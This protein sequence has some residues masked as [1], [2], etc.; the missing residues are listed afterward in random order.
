ML[1]H[2][3]QALNAAFGD[4][5]GVQAGTVYGPVTVHARPKDRDT[6][7]V[8]TVTPEE[9][10]HVTHEFVHPRNFGLAARVLADNRVV[11]LC[12]RGAGRSFAAR[13]LLSDLAPKDVAELDPETPLRG[14][15]P[16]D[17]TPGH[18]YVWEAPELER[19]TLADR[20]FR[21]IHGVVRAA[22]CWLVI[23]LDQASRAPESA[24]TATVTLGP[25][26]ASQVALETI[27][28]R[29]GADGSVEGPTLVLKRCLTSWLAEDDPPD[30]AVRAADFAIR[31]D[32]GTCELADASA[33]L[34]D[35]LD[36]SVR[37]WFE[38]WSHREYATALT[39]AFL[40]YQ[41]QE[42][43]VTH[44]MALEERFR[45]AELAEDEKLAPPR[46]FDKSLARTLRD[47]RALSE[48]RVHPGH[49]TLT[50][51]TVRF[52]RRGW[53]GAVLRHAWRQ[54]P[55]TRAV[56]RDWAFGNSMVL[57]FPEA[58]RR[59]LLTI[60][61]G[62]HEIEPLSVAEQLA[63]AQSYRVR[64][65]AARTLADLSAQPALEAPTR[66][67]LEGWVAG[68]TAYQKSTAAMVYSTSF[69]M[70][71]IGDT[72]ARLAAIGQSPRVTPQNA[73][74]A[75]V[76]EL[77]GRPEFE[78]S[79]LNTV[80][81]WTRAE[82]QSTGLR[83]V[84]LSIGLWVAGLWTDP[85][86]RTMFSDVA[87]RN[88]DAVRSLTRSVVRDPTFGPIALNRLADLAFR[89]SHEAEARRELLRLTKAVVP[90]LRW[91]CRWRAGADLAAA[92]PTQRLRI[93]HILR[94]ARK[95][96]RTLDRERP[97]GHEE[98]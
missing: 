47:V 10:S 90:D 21:Q 85:R 24:S 55:A 60:T 62:S 4:Q 53:A 7:V 80:V 63:G 52:E 69:G 18:G 3:G 78:R 39:V 95:A 81:S 84:S 9:I 31:V 56:L 13:R 20:D 8:R 98:G 17:L 23:V 94:A 42:V 89:A 22:R 5:L 67:L 27:G 68:G 11:V 25:P 79:V 49:R 54:Y 72:L 2:P 88:G 50:L 40:E 6:P 16:D 97:G 15:R 12:G 32:E 37:N 64:L 74:V 26:S 77:L 51:E 61:S 96:E 19:N 43:I 83:F 71:D 70:K 76:L 45:R 35:D 29:R 57:A 34:S 92:H 28:R 87:E 14:I 93:W 30:K 59:A 66:T 1:G 41:P 58:V 91:W 36:A 38:G 33:E 82:H 73:T 65:L 86:H 75:A 44:S 46:L 48:V